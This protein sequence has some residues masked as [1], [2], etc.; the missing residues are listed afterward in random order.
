M[1]N[2]S[3]YDPFTSQNGLNVI[4]VF[5]SVHCCSPDAFIALSVPQNRGFWP[6]LMLLLQQIDAQVVSATLSTCA[7]KS[8]H[9]IH[10]QVPT[11]SDID[12]DDLETLLTALIVQ[13]LGVMPCMV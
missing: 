3:K 9:F 4:S 10:A 1:G 12:N 8:F 5:L 6:A 11:G 2:N 7:N 13:E